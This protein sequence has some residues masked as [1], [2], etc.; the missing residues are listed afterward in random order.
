MLSKCQQRGFSLIE[1][2]VGIVIVSLLF[3]LAAPNFSVWMQNQQT[4]TAAESILNGI[5]LARSVAVK[6]NGTARLSLCALPTASWEVLAASAPI[7]GLP[8]ASLA[9]GAGSDAVAGEIRIQEHSG[10][11]GSLN[12]VV[13]PVGGITSVTF[14]N[15]GRVVGGVPARIDVTNPPKGDRQLSILVG[16]GGTI[17]MCD[18]SPLLIADDPRFCPPWP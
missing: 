7:L 4:R 6:N 2:L 15:L 14:N 12:S 3:A 1:L 10:Q 8:P 5:Q 16:G 9:C 13:A 11:E 18:P 17:R